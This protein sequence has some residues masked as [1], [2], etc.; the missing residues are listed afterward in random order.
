MTEKLKTLKD[1]EQIKTWEV[2]KEADSYYTV[3]LDELK[4]VAREWMHEAYLA[5]CPGV[6]WKVENIDNALAFNEGIEWFC[7]HFF[8]L[9]EDEDDS[10]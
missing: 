3:K 7:K 10:I 5:D 1:I 4:K 8:N 2:G 9:E 6:S